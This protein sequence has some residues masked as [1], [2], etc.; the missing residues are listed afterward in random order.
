MDNKFGWSKKE[1]IMLFSEVKKAQ[2]Q[3]KPLNKVFEKIASETGRK[4]NS[5]RNYY[6]QQVKT[7]K[8][9]DVELPSNFISFTDG[10]VKEL[11]KTMLKQQAQGK[12]VRKCALDL[13]GGDK[14][15]MLRYQNKYRS[16]IKSNP[17]L[18]NKVM[19]SL[20][21]KKIDYVN[22]YLNKQ[23]AP[24]V[25][26]KKTNKFSDVLGELLIN[27]Q[28]SGIEMDEMFTALNNLAKLAAR[29]A[30]LGQVNET[31]EKQQIVIKTLKR[32]IYDYTSEKNSLMFENAELMSRNRNLI[33]EG[34]KQRSKYDRIFMLLDKLLN[35]NREFLG[36][37]E[38]SMVTDLSTYIEELSKNI[39]YFEELKNLKA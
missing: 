24:T 28:S 23:V 29:N 10:A 13:G 7:H 1:T 37:N 21:K 16:V 4:A 3:A 18:V 6:Y 5:V 32:E 31:I 8:K 36:L 15:K 9:A 11:I 12:S 20:D 33:V 38:V 17:E 19:K 39:S 34:E 35:T 25:V 14:K 26:V 30:E 22:P 27:L 2:T